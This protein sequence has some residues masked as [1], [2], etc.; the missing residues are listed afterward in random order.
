MGSMGRSGYSE[1]CDGWELIM[2]RGAVA[3]AI[4]GRRGQSFLRTLIQALDA[5]PDKRLI[6]DDLVN[7]GEVCAIGS[8][9]VLHGLDMSKLDPENHEQLADTFDIAPALVQEIE[10]VNDD[11]YG[12]PKPSPEKRFEYVRKWAE[13]NLIAAEEAQAD[14][15]R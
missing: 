2:W 15:K 6:A 3:S 5:L 14:A 8:V 4:R 13:K 1:D 7:D 9:G 11:D 10:F 12:W